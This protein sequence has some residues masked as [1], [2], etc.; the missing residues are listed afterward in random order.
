[1]KALALVP[2]V[3]IGAVASAR[4]MTP[5]AA[6]AGARLAHRKTPGRLLL[7]DHPLFKFGG[8]AMGAGELFGDK[9]K[10]APEPDQQRLFVIAGGGQEPLEDETL[11]IGAYKVGPGVTLHLAMQDAARTASRRAAA[12]W[13]RC[14]I[15]F[16]PSRG[17]S[18]AGRSCTSR[19]T[20]T[21]GR[22]RRGGADDSSRCCRALRR[23]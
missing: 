10:S 15:L 22:R 7:L 20:R 4:S 1:M 2:S 21:L 23:A 3:L 19:Y 12:R 8:L 5:M 14:G 11:P 9:M 18:L 13:S 17:R 6:I 16:G